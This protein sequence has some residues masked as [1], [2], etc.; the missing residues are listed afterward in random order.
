MIDTFSRTFP[1]YTIDVMDDRSHSILSKL[2]QSV[3][4]ANVRYVSNEFEYHESQTFAAE[5]DF[6]IGVDGGGIN[7]MRPF[8]NSVTLF[9]F[10]NP[11]VWG[12]FPCGQS[13]ERTQLSDSWM[14][15]SVRIRPSRTVFRV[16]KK[17]FWLPSFQ[18]PLPRSFVSDFPIERFAEAIRAY[19]R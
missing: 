5:H 10:G 4:R 3:K 8:T 7:M 17:S 14:M 9:T 16:W 13:K 6:V 11:E 19:I 15:E 18:L 2:E 12:P 1:D